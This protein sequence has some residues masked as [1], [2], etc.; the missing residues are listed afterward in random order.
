MAKQ[1]QALATEGADDARCGAEVMSL[2]A[3]RLARETKISGDARKAKLEALNRCRN[4]FRG[5]ELFYKYQVAPRRKL[6]S[7]YLRG[8]LLSGAEVRPEYV[9]G[10]AELERLVKE[11]LVL[12]RAG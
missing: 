8:T 10:L 4:E 5:E 1:Q 11:G 3:E 12:R 2:E 7:K 6:E 9:G